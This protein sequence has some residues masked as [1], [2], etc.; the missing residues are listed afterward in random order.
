MVFEERGIWR[1]Y[2][3]FLDIINSPNH[4]VIVYDKRSKELYREQLERTPKKEKDMIYTFDEILEMFKNTLLSYP[5]EKVEIIEVQDLL[6][7]R[8]QDFI[9]KNSFRLLPCRF[10]RIFYRENQIDYLEGL[11]SEQNF[12]N[13]EYEMILDLSGLLY[14][15]DIYLRILN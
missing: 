4:I 13:I 1:L 2:I 14:F 6:E 12:I 8:W 3:H 15:M 11:E 7:E 10:I 5:K 9:I